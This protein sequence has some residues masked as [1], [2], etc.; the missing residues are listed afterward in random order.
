MTTTV[1]KITQFTGHQASVYALEQA[2]LPNLIFSAGSD[3][4]IA[5]WD[6]AQKA[7]YLQIE[8]LT[9]AK[10]IIGWYW[11]WACLCN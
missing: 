1:T 8:L 10:F 4:V 6:L 3:R 11:Y 2:H 5:R 9:S 7:A